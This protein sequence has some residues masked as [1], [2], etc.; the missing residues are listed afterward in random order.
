MK[1]S[2]PRKRLEGILAEVLSLLDGDTVHR[3]ID[4]SVDAAAS[5]FKVSDSIPTPINNETLLCI[6]G[7]FVAHIYE[8]GLPLSRV[9]TPE[10]A[11]AEAVYFLEHGYQGRNANGY[12]G[13]LRDTAKYG[14]DGLRIVFLALADVIKEV[15]RQ[16]HVRWVLNSRIQQLDWS[17]RRDL[18]ALILDRWGEF[19][20]E[21]VED[22]SPEELTSACADL[23]VDYAGSDMSLR[24]VF[25]APGQARGGAA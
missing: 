3:G 9:L 20:G 10:Q 16:R 5:T 12:E 17:T 1:N 6:V 24:Q 4:E 8:Y 14:K 19:L 13:A 21:V 2:L 18:T 7:E 15:Q 23:I 22:R 11:Q 25:S